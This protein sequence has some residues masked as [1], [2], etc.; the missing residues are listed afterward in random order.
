MVERVNGDSLSGETG[1]SEGCGDLE[2]A[3]EISFSHTKVD[4]RLSF[5]H[6]AVTSS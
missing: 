6:Y 5:N 1:T 3:A 2:S 4:Q